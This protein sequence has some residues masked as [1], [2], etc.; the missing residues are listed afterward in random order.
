MSEAVAIPPELTEQDL[1][2]VREMLQGLLD[3]V[4]RR[5]MERQIFAAVTTWMNAFSSFKRLRNRIGLPRAEAHKLYYGAILG[6]LKSSGKMLLVW[7][8]KEQCDPAQ[9][10]ISLLNLKACVHELIEDDSMLDRGLIDA[11]LSTFEK[12]YCA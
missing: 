6:G 10:G 8:E 3:D 12:Q 4:R 1:A 9:A 2:A 5:E 7:L 11:D